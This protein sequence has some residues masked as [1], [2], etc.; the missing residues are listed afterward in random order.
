[1]I[2]F[3]H[4]DIV[5]IPFGVFLLLFLQNISVDRNTGYS[6]CVRLRKTKF[7]T[8]DLYALYAVYM[9][10]IPSI[11]VSILCLLSAPCVP[12]IKYWLNHWV[13]GPGILGWI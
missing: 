4:V 11:L 13:L 1:M 10:I 12:D 9:H 7:Y 2:T 6:S 8:V 3:K 5:R